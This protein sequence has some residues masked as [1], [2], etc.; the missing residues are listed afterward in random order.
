LFSPPNYFDGYNIHRL[1]N[2]VNTV[3]KIINK[4]IDKF[5]VGVKLIKIINKLNEYSQRYGIDVVVD[6]KSLKK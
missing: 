1:I 4:E 3:I 6:T 5:N 2:K